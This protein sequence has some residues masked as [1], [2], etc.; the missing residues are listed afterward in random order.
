MDAIEMARN[1]TS[2]IEALESSMPNGYTTFDTY[3]QPVI[4][5]DFPGLEWWKA[6]SDLLR[7]PGRE[8]EKSALRS[9]LARSVRSRDGDRIYELVAALDPHLFE[10]K[11]SENLPAEEG[12]AD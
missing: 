11:C 6:T 5:S 1:L 2:R 3:D 12:D 8:A 10:G 7:N 9:Q 4:Q